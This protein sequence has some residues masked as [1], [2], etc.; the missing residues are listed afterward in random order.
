MLP[1]NPTQIPALYKQALGLQSAGKLEEA[2]AIFANILNV[3]P[4][5]AEVHFQ[6]GRIAMAKG[7]IEPAV[8]HLSAAARIKPGEAAIWAA[9][10]EAVLADSDDAHARAFLDAAKSAKAPP[11]FIARVQERLSPS[12]KG[13]RVSLGALNMAD[14]E[15]LTGLLRG[16]Q[17][18]EAEKV[19]KALAVSHPKSALVHDLLAA[20]EAQQGKLGAAEASLRRAIAADP[21]YAEAHNN[22]GRV[23]MMQNR[24]EEA[25]TEIRRAIRQLPG[26]ALAHQN[27][28]QLLVKRGQDEEAATVLAKAAKLAPNS[29]EVLRLLGTA[30]A[31]SRDDARAIATF[32]KLLKLAGPDAD[33]L[34]ALGQS[35]MAE[36]QEEAARES[37]AASL[38]LAPDVAQTH[39]RMGLLLQRTGDFDTAEAHFRKAIALEPANGEV[40]RYLTTGKRFAADDALV[41]QMQAVFEDPATDDTSRRHIGFALSKVMEDNKLYDRVF[42]YLRPANDLMRKAHPYD[43]ALRRREVDGIKALYGPVDFSGLSIPGTT[44][45]DPIFVTGMPR[46][47]TTLVEQIIASHSRVTG[48]GEIGHV[49]RGAYALSVQS[50]NNVFRRWSQI[51]PQMVANLGRDY[52]AYMRGRF[53]D[54]VQLT[55][56]SIQTY[57][58]MGPIML[59]LPRCRMVVVRRDP[60]DNLLSIYKNTFLEGSHLYAYDM[61]DLGAYYRMFVELIDFWRE[62]LPGRFYEIQY[63]E[64]VAHPEEEARKLI[65]A[66]GLEWEDACLSFYE[67]KRRV[68]TL[69]VY[70]VR[71]PIYASSTK[72]WKRYETELADLIEALGPEVSDGD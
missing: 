40:Y 66:C 36:G 13:S 1:I 53:P 21:N 22:L 2:V 15:R 42:T 8:N 68:D 31:R 39:V 45:F 43:I 32:Q 16:G 41:Q 25:E 48:A 3:R 19:A 29:V 57:S 69:S 44:E 18:A 72:A 12:K 33:V 64:L 49:A 51:T 4:N 26:L 23:L 11:A 7:K 20:A 17:L 70:Q 50:H 52:E 5:L 67:N 56:K 46:S 14:L 60:R 38:D 63:E 62:K 58:F 35:Q 27:L 9:F 10:A 54:A 47:G 55:D 71:Q 24:D 30:Q 61:K 6:L 28:G 65:A 59:A 37:Y 34:S